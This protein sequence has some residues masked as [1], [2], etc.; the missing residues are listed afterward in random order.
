M[1]WFECLAEAPRVRLVVGSQARDAVN[2]S[3]MKEKGMK[4]EDAFEIIATIYRSYREPVDELQVPL[5][6]GVAFG[7]TASAVSRRAD[8]EEILAA[9][10]AWD[11][12]AA[13]VAAEE[14][15]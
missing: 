7:A 5:R 3:L 11:R 8:S 1:R 14:E 13:I 15:L 4:E 9:T 12:L 10:A 6:P 2:S